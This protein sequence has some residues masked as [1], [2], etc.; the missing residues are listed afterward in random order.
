MPITGFTFLIGF[1]A[2]IAVPGTSGFFSKELILEAAHKAE[3]PLFWI[4]A[5]VALLTPFYMTRL[6]VVAFLGKTKSDHADHAH[7]VGPL[8]WGPLALLAVMGL[9]AGY[10][11]INKLAPALPE[12]AGKFHFGFIAIVSLVALIGGV[13]GGFLLYSGKTKDPLSIPLLQNRFYIDRLYD[14]FIVKYLQDALAAIVH[15]FD[16]L[17]ING[18]FVGGVSRGAQGLGLL[19]RRMQSGNLQT[20]AAFLGAGVLFVIYLVVF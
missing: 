10:P 16:E 11:F 2:L 8:M 13:L 3:S 20:Y 18:L 6:F 15:F 4:A 5:F 17:F 14:N 12:H 7:E 1:L 19:I 9:I